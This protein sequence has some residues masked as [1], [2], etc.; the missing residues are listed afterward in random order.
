MW[1]SVTA[2]ALNLRSRPV[3]Q[4]STRIAVLPQGQLVL[5]V[6][7][8]TEPG[9]VE[10]QTTLGGT[11]FR[12][13]VHGDWLAEAAAPAEPDATVSV[14]HRPPPVHLAPAKG[15]RASEAARAFPL[16]EASMPAPRDPASPVSTKIA[17]LHANVAWLAAPVSARY[18]PGGGA[19]Y[20]NIYA[21]DYATLAGA[22]LPR[23]WWMDRA[24]GEIATGGAAPA[25][26]Y[27]RTV[28]ELNANALYDWLA[29]WG[30]AY[31]W[32]RLAS[33]D[34]AQRAANVGQAVVACAQ[35]RDLSRS[36]H[37]AAVV[38]EADAPGGAKAVR[39]RGVVTKPLL[40]QAGSRNF[41]YEAN[42][43]FTGAQFRAFGFWGWG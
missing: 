31:G 8:S 42:G 34:D 24:L 36:G 25:A 20:C 11:T 17:S 12:G 28:R 39:S 27:G 15:E 5:E 22:Y 19:T 4:P 23:V 1:Y 16:G 30:G 7:P 9:W 2:T 29:E 35:R 40:C 18:R 43:F 38:P 41:D 32:Q 10:V 3:V 37:I 6:G 21:H 26:L 14:R 33:A 13:H